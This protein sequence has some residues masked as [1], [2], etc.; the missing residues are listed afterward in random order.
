MVSGWDGLRVS[1]TQSSLAALI[2]AAVFTSAA[3][4]GSSSDSSDISDQAAIKEAADH[5]FVFDRTPSADDYCTSYIELQRSDSF[6]HGDLASDAN[7]TESSCRKI[8]PRY[9]RHV[10]HTGWPNAQ[11]KRVEIDGDRGHVLVSFRERGRQTSRDAWTG[12]V[13]AG[14]WRILNAGYD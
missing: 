14:D 6:G 1:P 13:A 5:Y 3:C 8:L 11:I 12:K 9:V 2:L 7:R 4:G 10:G